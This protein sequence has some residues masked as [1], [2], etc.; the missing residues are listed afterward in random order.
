MKKILFNYFFKNHIGS[1][2]IVKV[3]NRLNEPNKCNDFDIWSIEAGAFGLNM[4]LI[5]VGMGEIKSWPQ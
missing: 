4:D 3:D 1:Q 5:F 2:W